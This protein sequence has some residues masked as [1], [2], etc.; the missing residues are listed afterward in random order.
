MKLKPDFNLKN[1]CGVNMVVAE[2]EQ[3]ID[4]DAIFSLNE[5]GAFL[6]REALKG[7]FTVQ[8]LADALLQEYEVEPDT[9]LKDVSAFVDKLREQKLIE[10]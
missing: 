10:E 5:T 8:T 4:F 6:W 9:A 1:V 3:N 2:G 7:D